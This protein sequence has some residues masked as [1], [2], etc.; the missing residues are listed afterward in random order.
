MKPLL[1]L[2]SG[3]LLASCGSA[4]TEPGAPTNTGT[5]Q[6][7]AKEDAWE[8]GSDPVGVDEDETLASEER[9][10]ASNDEN[11]KPPGNTVKETR[12]TEV[13][14]NIVTKNRKSVRACFD[15]LSKAEKGSGGTLTITF[16]LD[17]KGKVQSAKL[18]EARSTLKLPKLTNC[19]IGAIRK[20][21]FPPSSRG[22]ESTVNYPFDF[23]L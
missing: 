10:A 22:F 4:T 23:K 12:T 11:A 15:S 21:R 7:E 1:P 8:A 20:M 6:E 2:C 9:A 13:I 17:P 16:D 3:L 18:H 14:A 19:A 5:V